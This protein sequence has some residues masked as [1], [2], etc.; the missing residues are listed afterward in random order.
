LARK[1]TFEEIYSGHS[2]GGGSR[3]GPGSDPEHTV[4]YVRF[5]GRWLERHPECRRI[6]ELG[7]GDWATTRLIPI[8]QRHS[9]LGFDIVP[10]IIASNRE[11]FQFPNVR[12]ECGDFLSNVPPG[13]DLLLI[14]DVLQHLSNRSVQEFLQKILPQ[15]GHAIITNDIRKYKEQRLLGTLVFKRDLQR[16]N[17]DA[18]DGGSRPLKLDE[19]PFCLNVIQK[20]RYAVV[21]RNEP[22]RVVYEKDILV[23]RNWGP[24][25]TVS[26]VASGRV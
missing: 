22:R 20:F 3:S 9:Y 12:F 1:E 17:M 14:K 23:W 21:L 7:C 10:E 2:W 6:V 26:E 4:S 25:T 5:V 8:G 19:P 18:P 24:Q 15:F 11:N 16:P 13:G